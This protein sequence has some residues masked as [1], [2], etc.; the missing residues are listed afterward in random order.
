MKMIFSLIV[1]ALFYSI[2]F[3][4]MIIQKS[5]GIK[6]NQI[7]L[8]KEKKLHK[9]EMTMKTLT[10]IIVLIELMSIIFQWTY[11]NDPFPIIGFVIGLI[12][13]FIFLL[14][15]LQ[16]KDNWRAGIP[17]EDKTNL[18]TEG[19]YK[20]SRNPAFLGFDLM[21][22]GLL[23]LNFNILNLIITISTIIILHLQILQEEQ[24]MIQTFNDQ[25]LNYK[26]KVMRYFGRKKERN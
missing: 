22:I 26:R 14:A 16:M 18:V 1:M 23:L 20:I 12:G 24:Y 11:L 5:K 25:Y 9:I 13:D 2:Y 17:L 6:T 8:R 3:I 19:I 10:I 21:Y 4:K 15:V 7:G